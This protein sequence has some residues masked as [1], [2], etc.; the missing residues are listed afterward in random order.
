MQVECIGNRVCFEG[1]KS[2]TLDSCCLFGDKANA[3]RRKKGEIGGRYVAH[4][5]MGKLIKRV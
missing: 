3:S 5:G 4:S 2:V 1:Q